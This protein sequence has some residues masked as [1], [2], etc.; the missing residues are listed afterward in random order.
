MNLH[1]C[2]WHEC[3]ADRHRATEGET[4]AG[5]RDEVLHLR[6]PLSLYDDALG[7]LRLIFTR[8]CD[9]GEI[10]RS[11]EFGFE[12]AWPMYYG[13][14]LPLYRAIVDV[15]SWRRICRNGEGYRICIHTY[16]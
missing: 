11:L 15:Q 13:L 1:L 12:R 10:V 14:E 9:D 16:Q 8:R 2:P 4:A 7:L 6:V 5:N 3:D